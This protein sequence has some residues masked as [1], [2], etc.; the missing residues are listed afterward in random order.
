MELR[1]NA[2]MVS[3]NDKVS[4]LEKRW[5]KILSNVLNQKIDKAKAIEMF[6]YVQ[7]KL[8]KL[9]AQGI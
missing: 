7:K 2:I 8:D 4:S 3:K 9:D 5:Q 1:G 6:S